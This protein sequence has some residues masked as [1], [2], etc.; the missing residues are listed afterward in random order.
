MSCLGDEGWVYS[1]TDL[2]RN[3]G[4]F[5]ND[6]TRS[7]LNSKQGLR[8]RNVR[9]WCKYW[10]FFVPENDPSVTERLDFKNNKTSAT[11][12][13]AVA[14]TFGVA[15]PWVFQ[16]PVTSVSSVSSKITP[17]VPMISREKSPKWLIVVS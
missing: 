5:R 7:N 2:T 3:T 12:T 6:C 13:L 1:L 14:M 9:C 15:I 11:A 16:W 8:T 4:R 10:T 17:C